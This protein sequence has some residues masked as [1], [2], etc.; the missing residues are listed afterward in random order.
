MAI[1]FTNGT[2]PAIGSN[3]AWKALSL[4]Y[5]RSYSTGTDANGDTVTE[6][7]AQARIRTYTATGS[8][9]G[10]DIYTDLSAFLASM[11]AV[12]TAYACTA[13]SVVF[14]AV[15]STAVSLTYHDHPVGEAAMPVALGGH[16]ALAAFDISDY[17]PANGG[18]IG[19]PALA[20]LPG[21]TVEGDG[22]KT[23]AI[24]VTIDHV[25]V[26][27]R[28]E[29]QLDGVSRNCRVDVSVSGVGTA[30]TMASQAG[31][32]AAVLWVVDNEDGENSLDGNT[33]T[34]SG[35]VYVV[36]T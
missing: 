29:L 6:S 13:F 33:W 32:G 1:S 7:S 10:V 8:Y 28:N 20:G 15:A 21:F 23:F 12:V 31:G 19:V 9:N 3:L 14:D 35:H 24:N 36:R 4:S 25:D 34:R 27:G 22:I 30:P 16:T 11:P 17:M 2:P 18:A 26:N 5:P